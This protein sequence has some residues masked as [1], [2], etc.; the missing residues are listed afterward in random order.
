M[1]TDT[2]TLIIYALIG[3]I[4]LIVVLG[5]VYFIISSKDK[6]KKQDP[7]KQSPIKRQGEEDSE[8]KLESMK[9]FLDFDDVKD[10]MIIRK[11]RAQYVMVLQC[12]GVNYYLLSE[13]D[14]LAVE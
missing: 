13:E 5:I 4:A 6:K 10:N 11:N 7:S 2:T 3:V 9:D 1:N 8:I 12:Q 14:Q